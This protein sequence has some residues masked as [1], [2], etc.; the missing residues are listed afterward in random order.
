M[1]D[2]KKELKDFMKAVGYV[3]GEVHE[4]TKDGFGVEDL[5]SLKDLY[6]NR[7]MLRDGFNVPGDFKEH[8]KANFSIE[9]LTEIVAAAKEGFELGAK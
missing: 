3:A 6:D 1:V 2:P 5:K 9:D 7:K 8:L 4:I